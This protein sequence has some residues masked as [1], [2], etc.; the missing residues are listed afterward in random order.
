MIK[1]ILVFFVRLIYSIF[2]ILI[3]ILVFQ[4]ISLQYYPCME[5]IK[6]SLGK[7]DR[8]FNLPKQDLIKALK[9]GEK[10]WEDYSHRNLFDYVDDSKFK[11][12]LIYDGRQQRLD[13]IRSDNETISFNKDIISRGLTNL[14]NRKNNLE[15]RGEIFQKMLD[16]YYVD[17][18]NL[19]HDTELFNK[20]LGGSI[21]DLTQRQEELNNYFIK[22]KMEENIINKLT[23]TLQYDLQEY[24]K[25]VSNFNNQVEVFNQKYGEKMRFDQGMEGGGKIDL[26]Y[27]ENNDDLN[28]VIIHEMGH[29]LGLNHVQDPKSVMYFLLKEQDKKNIHLTDDDKKEF[30]KTCHFKSSYFEIVNSIYNKSLYITKYI[31]PYLDL[32]KLYA[33]PNLSPWLRK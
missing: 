23:A 32:L 18:E 21:D 4:K 19:N 6:Y 16:R 11:V 8:R 9:N 14:N 31:T 7:I 3:L 17:M 20:G 33:D 15:E 24:N 27:F 12:N 1:K 25:K 22:L 26:F 29:A 5:P 28:M 10:V 30:D 2:F 13:N